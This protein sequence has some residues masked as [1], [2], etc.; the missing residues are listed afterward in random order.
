M[1]ILIEFSVVFAMMFI[2]NGISC[3]IKFK[4]KSVHE[5]GCG[6][7]QMS[8]RFF[9]SETCN[10][11]NSRSFSFQKEKKKTNSTFSFSSVLSYRN[12]GN[13]SRQKC[14]RYFFFNHS[15]KMLGKQFLFSFNLNQFLNTLLQLSK[16]L[17]H[18]VKCLMFCSNNQHSRLRREC[19]Y[20]SVFQCYF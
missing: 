12:K 19:N 14:F 5:V 8:N 3:L 1:K 6:C 16:V 2:F 15:K 9:L 20:E 17:C 10:H 4:N 18:L 13:E 11:H 7:T